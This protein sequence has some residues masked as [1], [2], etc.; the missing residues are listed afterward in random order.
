[1]ST[2]LPNDDIANAAVIGGRDGSIEPIPYS[3][4]D[5][6]KGETF[7]PAA[8]TEAGEPRAAGTGPGGAS[9]T[10]WWKWTCPRSG[11]A[12]IDTLGSSTDN[13]LDPHGLDTQLA[14]Y[15]GPADGVTV[16]SLTLVAANDDQPP[17]GTELYGANSIVTFIAKA[18][19]TYYI[20]VDQYDTEQVGTLRLNWKVTTDNSK[21]KVRTRFWR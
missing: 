4:S 13:V 1:M 7:W 19:T 10:L 14:V 16:T 8:T 11:P 12:Q 18:D 9:E 21:V 20:Q 2:L 3:N 15:T 6:S 5:P 17:G